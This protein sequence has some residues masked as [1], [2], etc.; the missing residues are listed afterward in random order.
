MFSSHLSMNG[1]LQGKTC[2]IS[3]WFLL[4]LTLSL[5]QDRAQYMHIKGLSETNKKSTHDS[6]QQEQ[7]TPPSGKVFCTQ[8]LSR[9]I[10]R[11]S[12]L[13]ESTIL[14]LLRDG[15]GDERYVGK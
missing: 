13:W 12:N 8:F 2:F 3:L 11:F 4:S 15:K 14:F 5:K 6:Q 1:A 7:K 9:G 10:F